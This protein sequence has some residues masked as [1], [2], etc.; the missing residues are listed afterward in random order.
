MPDTTEIVHKFWKSLRSDM[1]AMVGLDAGA[2]VPP[3]P[4]TAQ[5]LDDEDSGPIFFFTA[6]DTLLAKALAAGSSSA[7][8]T[9]ASKGHDLFA[10]VEGMIALHDDRATIDTL[11]NPFVAAWFEGGKD[12]PKLALLRF[13]PR[14]AEIWL[15]G[16]SLMAGLR[17][18]LGGDPKKDYEGN[19]AK[20][21]LG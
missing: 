9:F 18:L 8:M 7:I 10:T 3:R 15:D 13:D 11:W 6:K 2:K 16:S 19:V 21:A 17:I 4:M 12:D 14:D 1:T 5:M 20:V